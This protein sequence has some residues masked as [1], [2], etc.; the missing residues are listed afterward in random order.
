M[1]DCPHVCFSGRLAA[2]VLCAWLLS[3]PWGASAAEGLSITE[4]APGI[5]LH[6]GVQEETSRA[7]RGDIAN[8]GFIVGAQRVAVIDTG[9]SLA[10]GRALRAAIRRVTNLPIAYVILTHMHPDH[11]LGAKAFEQDGPE[12]IG[13]VNLPD[14]L[15][16]R[17]TFYLQRARAELGD[18]AEGTRVVMPTSTVADARRL[19]LGGRMLELRA[20]PTAHTNNDLS[21]F[22]EKT[23]TLW[24]SDLLFVG[25]LPVIDGSLLG[26]L[27]VMDGLAHDQAAKVVPGHGPVPDDWRTALAD[28]RRYLETVAAGVRKVIQR[29]GTIEDA[30]AE[31][32]Q[33]ERASWL[34]FDA[35]NGRNV[36]AAFVELEW[37]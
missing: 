24:L 27:R 18:E 9:G 23:G 35:Y 34:L 7:N 5:Y 15:A 33:G 12:F 21:V 22:D 31:V 11:V 20:Y 25:R 13:H 1:F 2:V 8:I 28:Q 19:D 30:V 16:R 29:R 6:Q 32:A 14:A 10:E 36:T 3:L 17:G 37:E 26:W 4:I